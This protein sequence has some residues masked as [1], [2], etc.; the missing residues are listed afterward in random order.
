MSMSTTKSAD[1]SLDVCAYKGDTW[2]ARLSGANAR[3]V[4]RVTEDRRS[5]S[6]MTGTVRYQGLDDGVYESYEARSGEETF[7]IVTSGEYRVVS[8]EEALAAL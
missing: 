6:R 5:R 1:I 2:L 4:V 3:T 7:Y 8:R